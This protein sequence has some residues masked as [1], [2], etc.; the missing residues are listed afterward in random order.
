MLA[1]EP[2]RAGEKSRIFTVTPAP[3]PDRASRVLLLNDDRVAAARP[4]AY[5]GAFGLGRVTVVGFDL[6]RPPV[7]DWASRGA[8]WEWLLNEA[9]P[10][11]GARDFQSRAYQTDNP[12]ALLAG[13]QTH[14]DTFEGV[15][16]ISFGWVALFILGYIVLIG[17]VD[18]LVLKKVFGRLEWTWVT[19]PL[20]VLLVSLGAYYAAYELKGRDLKVNKLDLVEVDLGGGRVYGRTYFTVFS[21]RMHYYT[22]GVE[23]VTAGEGNAFAWAGTSAAEPSPGVNLGW[24]GKAKQLRQS[25][26]SRS[27]AVRSGTTPEGQEFNA[28]LERVPIAVWSTKSFAADWSAPLADTPLVESTLQVNTQNPNLL[29]GNLTSH[30]PDD[31]LA[32]AR[33]VWRNQ[34]FDL[35]GLARDVPKRV[36]IDLDRGGLRSADDWARNDLGT[37]AA[38]A[39]RPGGAPATASQFNLW[40]LGFA[41]K[42]FGNSSAGASDFARQF[43]QS[44][45]LS[46]AW[47]D[48]AIFLART[49]RTERPAED[50]SRDPASPTRLWVGD[51]PGPGKSRP[52]LPGSLRQEVFVRAYLPVKPPTPGAK[53]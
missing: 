42:R 37:S 20:I 46:P 19:F 33:L 43:D 53:P 3:R 26:I 22:L 40:Q 13:L 4:L 38:P 48:Q 31:A 51:T 17:P 9:G 52:A 24:Q 44:W 16:V 36:V 32:E 35:P 8:F 12:D 7:T 49:Y 1:L 30:L 14:L 23:P 10:K 29:I 27:Y 6:D 15:P 34:V 47:A 5:Q 21:P 11:L 18:Y 50:Y 45:R 41:D 39:N 28:G 25:G 2:L